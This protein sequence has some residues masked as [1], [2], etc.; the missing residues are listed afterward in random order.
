MGDLPES[1]WTMRD[2][3][4]GEVR[5]G[6]SVAGEFIWLEGN[7][8]CDHNRVTDFYGHGSPEDE[9]CDSCSMMPDG[10]Q[11]FVLL[12]LVS[13]QGRVEFEG[14]DPEGPDYRG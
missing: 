1:T 14:E 11:R 10:S 3:L 13:D 12:K 2:R 4:T 6:K 5:T 9:S 7:W 8:A